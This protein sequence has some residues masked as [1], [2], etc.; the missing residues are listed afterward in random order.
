MENIL[1]YIIWQKDFKMIFFLGNKTTTTTMELNRQQ[2]TEKETEK[3]KL[4]LIIKRMK[5][6]WLPKRQTEKFFPWKF[7]VAKPLQ[8]S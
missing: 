5:T 3:K 1:S 6:C 7:I 8:T 4:Y 2:N